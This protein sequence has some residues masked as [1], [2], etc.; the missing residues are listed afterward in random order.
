MPAAPGRHTPGIV[1]PGIMT[2]TKQNRSIVQRAASVPD[3]AVIVTTYQRVG[4][5]ERCLESLAVQEG[6]PAGLEVVVADD[7]SSD[8]TRSVVRAFARRAPFPVQFTTHLH[9]GF[10]LA[11]CRN[12]G[13]EATVAPYLV[14]VDGD[15]VLPRRFLL[16]HWRHRQP[17]CVL[18]G[19]VVWLDRDRSEKLTTVSIAQSDPAHV[20]SPAMRRRLR[21]HYWKSQLYTLARHPRRPRLLGGACSMWRCDF[22]QVNG[23]DRQFRGWG[24]EDDDLRERLLRVGVRVRPVPPAGVP[25]HRWHR[26]HPTAPSTWREGPNIAY[27]RRPGKLTCC[28]HGLR[29]RPRESVRLHIVDPEKRLGQDPAIAEVLTSYGRAGTPAQAEVEVIALP[30]P[31]VRVPTRR[32]DCRIVIA[33]SPLHRAHRRLQTADY[34]LVDRRRFPDAPSSWHDIRTLRAILA[35]A[36]GAA[37]E[38]PPLAIPGD[39]A[40]AA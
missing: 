2:Q 32:A 31:H 39:P 27:L 16:T 30:A 4:H 40:Q 21:R 36:T 15:C 34:V 3:M 8:M 9:D 1:T 20:L 14:F 5:L 29:R 38:A 11:R 7:G 25:L 24:A 23:Y 22:E 19:D 37:R 28:F 33:G 26:K 18:S 13:V 6:Y 17:G 35:W 12:E 10:Q